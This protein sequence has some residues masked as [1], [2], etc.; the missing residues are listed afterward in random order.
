MHGESENTD[1][2]PAPT[3]RDALD[4]SLTDVIDQLKRSAFMRALERRPDADV[5]HAY[6]R[7]IEAAYLVRVKSP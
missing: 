2:A 6:R 5:Y 3:S 7:T 4:G 1:T